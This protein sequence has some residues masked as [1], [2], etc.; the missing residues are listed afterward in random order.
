M[1]HKLPNNSRFKIL[2]ND[3]T[4]WKKSL[5]P[6]L[7]S[8]YK[9]LLIAYKNHLKI[10]LEVLWF[11]PFC[12]ISLFYFKY[13]ALGCRGPLKQ[14]YHLY[15]STLFWLF[16]SCFCLIIK[17]S[18]LKTRLKLEFHKKL[19]SESRME[20]LCGCKFRPNRLVKSQERQK[21]IHRRE[22]LN[23]QVSCW[24]FNNLINIKR[25]ICEKY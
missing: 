1:S 18:I 2:G 10:D 3:E 5:V 20:K 9:T 13:F 17:I 15:I 14:I 22:I 12:L 21:K 25:R 11:C 19:K 7:P 23:L 8:R 24:Y 16:L 4:E 6:G